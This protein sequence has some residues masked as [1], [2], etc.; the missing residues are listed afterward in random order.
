[1]DKATLKLT[2]VTIREL[3]SNT[4]SSL[5]DASRAL[6][7]KKRDIRILRNLDKPAFSVVFARLDEVALRGEI[8]ALL[9]ADF[10]NAKA[11]VIPAAGISGAAIFEKYFQKHPPFGPAKKKAEF[12][13]AFV[14]TALEEWCHC[15]KETLYVVSTDG[16]M[17]SACNEAGPLLQLKSIAE[18]VDLVLREEDDQADFLAQFFTDNPQRLIDAIIDNFQ[19]QTVYLADEDGSGEP[20]VN[21]VTLGAAAVV[22]MSE[23]EIVLE[24]DA[25]IAFTTSVSYADPNAISYDNEDHTTMVWNYINDDLDGEETVPVEVTIAYDKEDYLDY[26]VIDIKVNNGES[27][28]SYVDEDAKTHW[29]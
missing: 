13:D 6:E 15:H 3:E 27:V 8:L 28:T 25:T 20:S 24:F 22:S 14:L 17:Q 5:V 16:D 21:Q 19:D 29:K 2:D 7:A 23:D 9:Q 4:E 26:Q 11:E 1:M 10:T 12:P 18:F